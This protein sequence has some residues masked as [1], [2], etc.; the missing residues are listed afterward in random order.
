MKENIQSYID[1]A[2]NGD[3][4]AYDWL[5]NRYK[6]GIYNLI[7]QMIKNQE[8]TRDLVQETF[9][10]AFNSLD[11]YNCKYAFSTW[12]YKIAY[13]HS[14]DA[15]RKNKLKTLPLDRP[16]Q[17]KEGTVKQQIRDE[18]QSP[19]KKLLF[20]EKQQLLHEVIESLPER[21]SRPII[22][23]HS[24]ERS[25]EEISQILNIPI[26]TVKARIFR[27]REM[28]KKKMLEKM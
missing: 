24:E 6:N 15:I 26:G 2:L 22:L 13:N 28:I 7:F 27:A 25:Y 19:E 21:Y 20:K 18:S 9:I 16:I 23:R 17:L 12:L 8:E 10:K 14:I 3:E 1:R 4:K 11:S 5:L